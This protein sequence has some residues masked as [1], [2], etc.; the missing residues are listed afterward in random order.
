MRILYVVAN[1]PPRH[2]GRARQALMLAGALNTHPGVRVQVISLDQGP[3]I[4]PPHAP[5]L[6]LRL[7][8]WQAPRVWR[9]LLWFCLR[10]RIQVV[11]SMVTPM[12]ST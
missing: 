7:D 3:R 9:A 12:P 2:S 6:C 1:A 4:P 11:I 10:Q 5:P 8:I